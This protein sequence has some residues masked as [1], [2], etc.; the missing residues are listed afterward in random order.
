LQDKLN[1]MAL[2]ISHEARYFQ[3]MELS[4]AGDDPAKLRYPLLE[5]PFVETEASLALRAQCSANALVAL[6]DHFDKLL[7]T[8]PE[9][10]GNEDRQLQVLEEL[11]RENDAAGA[12]LDAETASAEATLAKLRDALTVIGADR[13]ADALAQLTHHAEL[14]TRGLDLKAQPGGL[15]QHW[16]P[17]GTPQSDQL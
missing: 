7:G 16:H 4:E 12:M 15:Q 10:E 5:E 1:D 11:A 6:N 3:D 8:L 2:R 13:S 17:P 9:G 14:A